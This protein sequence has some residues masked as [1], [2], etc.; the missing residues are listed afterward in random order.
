[1][2]VW[3]VDVADVERAGRILAADPEV[4]HCYERSSSPA[5]PF[6]L[7]AMIHA[8]ERS[9]AESTFQRLSTQAGLSG[10]RMLVSVREFKKSSPVFFV[11]KGD[12]PEAAKG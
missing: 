4:T 9:T 3:P 2:C 5:V 12:R 6:N 11:E 1:M 10:G 7:Y 8:R